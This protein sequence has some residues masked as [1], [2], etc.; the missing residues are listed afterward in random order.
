MKKNTWFLFFT[1][2]ILAACGGRKD[3]S[4]QKKIAVVTST[5]VATGDFMTFKDYPTSIEGII[6]SEARAKIS[7]YISE[8]YVD[9]GE[10]V[11]K[12]ELLFRIE[13][14]SLTKEAEAAKAQVDAAQI[15]V[16][17][18]IPL[19]EQQVISGSQLETAKANLKQAESK[20]ASVL[21][22]IEYANVRSPVDGYV[23]EIR[24]RKGNLVSPADPKPLTTVSDISKVYAYFSMNE[25]T[26]LN[27][28]KS[29]EGKTMQE[30][31]A[32]LPEITLIMANGDEYPLKGTIQTINSQVDK[33]TG[34]ISFRAIFDNPDRLL[35][36]GSTGIIKIPNQYK[37]VLAV[38]RKSTYEQQGIVYVF[39]V[40]KTDTVTLA[41]N[42]IIQVLDKTESLY[43]VKSGVEA[44]EEIVADGLKKIRPG[45]PIQTT[46]LPFD[47]V[48]KPLPILFR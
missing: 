28:L 45:M 11:S 39:K 27:F 30:R 36:N 37:N 20:Y 38:P 9:E 1:G 48:A 15:Q 35:T 19:V 26:Y 41:I 42:K 47:S 2:L 10:K 33:T 5:N 24:I 14:E 4:V 22:N 6:N 12:G 25:K 46:L 32:H 31:I 44:G 16:D 34:T 29:A 18:L 13:T 3:Q 43:L 23:G 8:V 7:G 40:E 17:Q 21:A